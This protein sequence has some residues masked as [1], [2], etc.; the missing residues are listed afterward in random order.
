LAPQVVEEPELA[1]RARAVSRD[2]LEA[3]EHQLALERRI[4]RGLARGEA[5]R[6]PTKEQLSAVG[7][8]KRNK[9]TLHQGAAPGWRSPRLRKPRLV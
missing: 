5:R 3:R 4:E 6:G 7:E 1:E 9:S 8:R 2:E